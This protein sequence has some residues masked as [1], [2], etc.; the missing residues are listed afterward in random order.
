MDADRYGEQLARWVLG[1]L[2]PEETAE[3]RRE[4]ERRGGAGRA[5]AE[6]MR[7]IIGSIG[8]AAQPHEPPPAL[9]DRVLSAIASEAGGE[10]E[11]DDLAARAAAGR[12]AH[13]RGRLWPW[14][15][16][17]ATVAA[18]GLGLYAMGLRESL[19][20]TREE[21]R[22]AEAR[23]GQADA[24]EDSLA[25]LVGDLSAL[26]D[27]RA[28]T[29]S[30]TSAEVTGRARVFVDLQ[31]G[32]TLLLVDELP[33]LPPEQVYQLWAIRGGEP[34]SAGVFRFEREGPAWIELPDASDVSAAEL[35][36]VT[37]ERAPGAPAPTGDPIL[38]GEI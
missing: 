38:A 27:S 15:A 29:L 28:V 6:R 8:L 13:R 2:S 31:T 26:V 7:E 18:I 36:A 17:A 9:R 33:V 34:T 22:G 1:E 21:L 3:L 35:L 12:P 30:G 19:N 24:L 25:D 16:V 23:A 10:T 37:I 4:M 11:T 32:R 5:E 20:S 14:T